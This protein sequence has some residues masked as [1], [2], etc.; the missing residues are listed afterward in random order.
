MH[1][2]LQCAH[3]RKRVSRCCYQVL[4]HELADD[5]HTCK[6]GTIQFHCHLALDFG[7]LAHILC[8]K[9]PSTFSLSFPCHA[10]SFDFH[11]STLQQWLYWL[12]MCG[13][14]P[15][16][17]SSL[18]FHLCYIAQDK[19]G[20]IRQGSPEE[21]RALGQHV[22]ALAPSPKQLT[23]TSQLTELL[24]LLGKLHCFPKND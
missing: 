7:I 22:A 15:F 19:G 21:E 11:C 6:Q 5:Q 20:R 3:I 8:V 4:R 16:T 23:E 14:A 17:L 10:W 12:C 18:V 24:T 13:V 2:C 9:V 1:C